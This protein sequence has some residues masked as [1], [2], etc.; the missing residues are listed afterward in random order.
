MINLQVEG[1]GDELSLV[2]VED[3][4][5]IQVAGQLRNLKGECSRSKKPPVERMIISSTENYS[6]EHRKP[7][8]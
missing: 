1:V 3:R 8:T 2:Q 6:M 5:G 4:H 7:I